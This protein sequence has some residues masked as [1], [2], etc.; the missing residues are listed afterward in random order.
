M[1]WDLHWKLAGKY[2]YNYN[3]IADPQSGSA[4]ALQL[5]IDG[6]KLQPCAPDFVSG[7]NAILLA[8]QLNGG[9]DECDIWEVFAKRGLGVNATS[10]SPTDIRRFCPSNKMPLFS[11]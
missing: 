8:D 11:Y 1:L 2:G 5:V 9:I 3:V 7:R 10:G 4:K 6:L